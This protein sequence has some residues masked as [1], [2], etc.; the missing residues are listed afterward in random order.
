MKTCKVMILLCFVTF[1]SYGCATVDTI[2][3]AKPGS[4]KFFSG[5]RLDVNA[6]AGNKVAVRKF[7]VQPPAYPLLD[8][9]ASFILDLIIAPVTGGVALYEVI[10][11]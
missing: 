8:L 7:K 4:P 6:L 5:T 2:S 10:F 11:D 3:N 9:P 1:N